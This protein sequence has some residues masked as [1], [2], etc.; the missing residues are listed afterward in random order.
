MAGALAAQEGMTV[1][2]DSSLEWLELN[3]ED[4][5]WGNMNFFNEGWVDIFSDYLPSQITC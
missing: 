2:T 5:P 1:Y 4:D 3:K